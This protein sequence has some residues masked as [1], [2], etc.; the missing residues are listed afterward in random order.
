[1]NKSKV[2]EVC[3]KHPYIVGGILLVSLWMAGLLTKTVF[4]FPIFI[5]AQTAFGVVI[6]RT[7]ENWGS[8]WRALGKCLGLSYA[9]ITCATISAG[10]IMKL[11]HIPSFAFLLTAT[12]AM[13]PFI[14]L[15]IFWGWR[16]DVVKKASD[17]P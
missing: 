1:M 3:D 4:S 11:A 16:G 12:L 2:I 7:V 14:A 13:T 9:L 5:L 15:G 8:Y 10:F 17:T 6:G